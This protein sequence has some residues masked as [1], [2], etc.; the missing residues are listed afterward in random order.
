MTEK[1]TIP[2]LIFRATKMLHTASGD[3][4]LDIGFQLKQGSILAL[5]GPSGAG[6]TTILRI[7]AGLTDTTTGYIQTGG[8]NSDDSQSSDNTN[9]SKTGDNTN[10]SKTSD[11]TK[12][13][14]NSNNTKPGKSTT[15]GGIWL[16]TSHHINLPTRHRSIGFVFQDFALF[17]H[18]TVRQQLEFALP[19]RSDRSIVDELL[20]MMELEELQHR[21]PTL[22]S[23]GQQQRV[24]LARA[25]A[26]RPRLLLLDEPLSALDDEMR[27]RLQD[28]ILKAH[29]FYQ[30]TTILV[31]HYLPEIFRLSDEVIVLENGQVR[32]QDTAANI[33]LEQK[34]SSKFRATG[35]I[36]DIQP[37]DIVCIVSVLSGNS[38]VKVV[39]TTAEAAALHIGQKV[40]IASKAFNPIILPLG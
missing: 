26:R 12:G 29:R 31:S 40:V 32:K 17:P 22:L 18:L 19:K 35:E 24:A 7:L 15:N 4:L 3:Q 39:A 30:L 28:F 27:H 20:A 13:G 38:I 37:A 6:K 34:I 25:I 5:Y 11:N 8:G 16:D 10:Y 1:P 2:T 21:K 14:K 36:I 9:Y 33:F 23:G